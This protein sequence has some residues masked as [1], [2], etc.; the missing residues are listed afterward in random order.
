MATRLCWA[1]T[2]IEARLLVAPWYVLHTERTWDLELVASTDYGAGVL[3]MAAGVASWLSVS[4]D[5][6]ASWAPLGTDVQAGVQL[7]AVSAGGR[8]P[9]KVKLDIPAGTS[10]RSRLVALPIGEGM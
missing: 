9:L 8:I 10:V 1:G 7:G 3:R 6:G 2:N 4:L 5:G